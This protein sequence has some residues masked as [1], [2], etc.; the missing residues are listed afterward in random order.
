MMRTP[1]HRRLLAA[2]AAVAMTM[3]SAAIAPS[4][5]AQQAPA[6]APTADAS[7]P[8][9]LVI[10][11]D[12]V[13]Q[14]N[15]SAYS[16]GVVGYKTPNIDSIAKSGMM[17]TDY[18][19]ENSCTAGRSTFITGQT[20]LRTGLC[21]VGA[22][23][24]PVG[25]QASDITIAQAL[26]PLGY[27][28]GQFG[29]NHLG[30]RDEYLPTKHGFDEFFGNL[31]HLNAEEEPEAPYWPKD[32]A[33]FLKAYSPRGVIKASADGK[34]EDSGPLTKKRMETIDDETSAAAMDFMDRQVKAKKPFFTWMNATRMHVFTH[35]RES[36]RGQS[37]MVGNEYADGM[38]EHD[39]MVGKIL[40]K[41]E[42]LGI[43]DNTIVV[44]TTDNGP[45]QWSWPDAA[46]TPFRSEKDTNWEG[47]FRVPAMV[48]WPGHIQPGQ[49]SNGMMSGLD[50]FP[51]LLAAAG[52]P[53][54]KSRLL[55]G[56]KP[57]GS[58]SSFRNHLDGYNQLDYLTGK[59]DKSA[60]HDFY[61]FDDDGDLV[62]T[63]YD[64]WKVVFKEQQLPGG[65]AVW[66][67]PLVTWRIPK[68]F[69]LRMD[70]YERADVVSDQYND[71]VVRNDYLLVKGQ[72]QGAA[73]LETFVKYPP[74]Q[75]VAS[76]NIEGVREEVDK[77]IDQSFKDR[78]IEK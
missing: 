26:K 78:G 61:Y 4:V 40:K 30:D 71:F 13:G 64:D 24:A 75:R 43:T 50:W 27:A 9:I 34:I 59:T 42:E 73:F 57:D 69:N 32:D 76:F 72:L 67:N 54:V 38:V 22:P 8:N 35:V 15:I 17:F 20:C 19:A 33:E 51:T 3:T 28:T 5:S 14:T 10:F 62:A 66:Q 63:R 2:A 45:N 49:V 55:S 1:I 48:K 41:L 44:Y 52:D 56:W 70:P 37:G 23:G 29:K 46:T 36:M 47:A 11:G 6:T 16:F 77:A 21:K 12:D 58:A 53:D 60:R 7:K 74:S 31:Y 65:F 39:Q 25:L 68:L 18:Y